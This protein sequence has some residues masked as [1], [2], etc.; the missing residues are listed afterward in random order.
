MAS[1]YGVNVVTGVSASRPIVVNSKTPIYIV[2]TVVL[3]GLG[4]VTKKSIQDNDGILHY[5]SITEANDAFKDSVGT[6][7][8][9]LD[10]ILDQ[11]VNCPIVISTRVISQPQSEKEAEKFHEVAVIKSDIIK[12][13]AKA[14][15]AMAVYGVKANIIIAPRFS[16]D[17][18]VYAQIEITSTLLSGTGIVDLNATNEADATLKVKKFGTRRLLVTDPYVKVWDTKT[19]GTITEPM[20][21]RVAGMIAHSDG[22]KEYGWALSASNTVMQGIS[23][24]ARPIEFI[25]GQECEADRLRTLG[26]S[27]IINYRGFRLWGFE[28]TDPDTV[29]KSLERVRV[30]DRVGEALLG[31]VFWAIDRGADILIHAKDS[32]DGLLLSLKG[33]GVLVG[34]DVF[35]HPSK[36]TKE[37]LTAGK[38]YLVADMQNMP[39]VKRFEIECNF[40]DE[41]SPILMKIIGG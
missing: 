17:E 14:S 31:G 28:T 8:G 30:F 23:G 39:T 1:N 2:G 12:G 41:F 26:I 25:A 15:T 22:L 29:W 5:S 16:H 13:I 3:A 35:W 40:T 10:G 7:R 18:D 21:A 34:Y 27:T 11:G 20:S 32:V 33:A 6:L 37:A 24:T 38:F 9:A 36:N 4:D 19:D